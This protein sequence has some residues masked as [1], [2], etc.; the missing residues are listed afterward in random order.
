MKVAYILWRSAA[1]R[2][3]RLKRKAWSARSSASPW[4]RLIS[5]CAGAGF[6]DQ[7]VDVEVLRLAERVD[8]VEQRVELVD[9]RDAVGLAA[10]FRAAGA[11]DRGL[12]RIVRVGVR[13]DEEELE[14]RRDHR[15][16]AARGVEIEHAA[17]HVARRHRHRPAVAVEAVVDH[18]RRRLRRPGHDARS[19]SGRPSGRCRFPTDESEL[20]SSGYSP[21][22]VCRKMDSGRRMPSSS[23]YLSA[24]MILPRATPAMSGMIA[25]TSVISGPQEL[26]DL[27]HGTRL[28]A[29]SRP[30]WPNA[31]NSA[32]ENGLSMTFH[33]GCHCTASAKVGAP[34]RG[35]PRP[36]RPPPSP[37]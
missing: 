25:S 11:A 24:G 28:A 35:R 16:P 4:I 37:R 12:Q 33:S 10:D 19:S 23:A 8:V 2:A 21:V 36:R 32:R 18:L 20:S 6:V 34:R 1:S 15:P 5:I 26:L 31:A 9:R 30:A 17:Q 29:R 7:R 27:T 13:L 3:V 14:F 22:T